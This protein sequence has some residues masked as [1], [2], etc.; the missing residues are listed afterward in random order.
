MIFIKKT[1]FLSLLLCLNINAKTR[2]KYPKTNSEI[3]QSNEDL[4]YINT[5]KIN[6]A[7]RK[8]KFEIIRGNTQKANLLLTQAKYTTDFSKTI[9]YR[10]QAI[11]FFVDSNYSKVLEIL[12]KNEFNL[13]TNYQKVCAIKTFSYLAI[14][15]YKNSKEEW[16]KCFG[17]TYFKSKSYNLWLDSFVYRREFKEKYIQE[18]FKKAPADSLK[19][20][21]KLAI[22]LDQQ[23]EVL[24]YIQYI[25]I[26]SL[27]NTEVRELIA[28]AYYK[29]GNVAKTYEFMEGLETS[30]ILSIKGN[31]L[32]LQ[33]KYEMAYSQFK[34]AYKKKKTST[35]AVKR[36]IPLSWIYKK[37]DEALEYSSSE[38]Q[39]T[40]ESDI[41]LFQAAVLSQKREFKSSNNLLLYQIKQKN[42]NSTSINANLLLAFNY[43]NLEKNTSAQSFT[44]KACYQKDGLSCLFQY[45][46]SY[47]DNFAKTIN[48][49]S[50]IIRSDILSKYIEKEI[51][52]P[53]GDKQIINQRN[54]E[55]LDEQDG[56]I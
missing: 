47:W 43:I 24:K 33:G 4:N 40:K 34:L 39:D 28:F 26:K 21:L 6:E 37:W 19:L 3:V 17:I 13:N 16:K 50:E 48:S 29:D 5:Q 53:L 14:G 15:E 31:F 56:H 2:F 49:E 11:S 20:F 41:G 52:E 54:L 44:E 42:K 1:I 32:I 7:L 18:T 27:A 36:L 35:N 38:N 8:I 46:F 10:Y 25:N 23:K 51:N 9:Q 30:N 45:H 55:L 22:Y 12:N